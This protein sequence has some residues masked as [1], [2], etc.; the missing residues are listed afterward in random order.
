MPVALFVAGG[1]IGIIFVFGYND[2]K[3]LKKSAN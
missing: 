2:N 3:H 1:D